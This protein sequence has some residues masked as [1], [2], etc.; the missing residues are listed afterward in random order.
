MAL[1]IP[2]I[3][4][5]HFQHLVRHRRIDAD[6]YFADRAAIR[7]QVSVIDQ[8]SVELAKRQPACRGHVEDFSLIADQRRF[9]IE[10]DRKR[11]LHFT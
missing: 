9:R 10:F 3:A 1:G 5:R 11:S 4:G 2:G 6:A 7:H 8:Q